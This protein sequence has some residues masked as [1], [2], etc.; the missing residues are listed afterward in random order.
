MIA[1]VVIVAVQFAV[2]LIIA[3]LEIYAIR[4]DEEDQVTFSNLMWMMFWRRPWT[5]YL[6]GSIIISIILFAG[7]AFIHL[8]WGPCAWGIC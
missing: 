4:N 8:M 6:V 3:A 7:W 5:R 1:W 2:L